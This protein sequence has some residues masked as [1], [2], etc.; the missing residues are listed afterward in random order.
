MEISELLEQLSKVGLGGM[1]WVISYILWK[2]VEKL[3]DTNA[4]NREAEIETKGRMASALHNLT[5]VIKE[6][7]P[8]EVS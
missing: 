6:R 2:R 8:R 4:V 3:T 7:L 1:G 5:D